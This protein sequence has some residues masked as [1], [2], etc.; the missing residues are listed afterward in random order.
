MA[1][2]GNRVSAVS[3][4][5]DRGPYQPPTHEPMPQT[6]L[7]TNKT[8]SEPLRPRFEPQTWRGNTEF[9]TQQLSQLI[10]LAEA[11]T[12]QPSGYPVSPEDMLL[13]AVVRSVPSVEFPQWC[14]IFPS[15]HH[16]VVIITFPTT[17]D[18]S[19]AKQVCSG[20]D[21]CSLPLY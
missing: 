16:C 5:L 2:I 7:L 6:L 18:L 4:A 20:D 17:I 21:T 8:D 10:A 11:E 15:S 3:G 13:A 12:G 9:T 1:R 19:M 14:L